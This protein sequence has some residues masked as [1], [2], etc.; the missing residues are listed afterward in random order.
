VVAT[1]SQL[2]AALLDERREVI[3]QLTSDQL[4]QAGSA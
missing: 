3:E 1:G 2:A 4:L